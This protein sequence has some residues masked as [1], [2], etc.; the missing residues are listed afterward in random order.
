MLVAGAGLAACVF[1]QGCIC[2]FPG[3]APRADC[4]KTDSCDDLSVPDDLAARDQAVP[5]LRD[6]AQSGDLRDEDAGD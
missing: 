3:T 4:S 6:A 2:I 5:D 1:N